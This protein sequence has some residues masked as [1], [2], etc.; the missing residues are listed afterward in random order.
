MPIGYHRDVSAAS[1]TEA[2][3]RSDSGA[4]AAQTFDGKPVAP[5]HKRGYWPPD[6]IVL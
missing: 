5:P 4:V 3:V 2:L 6:N 1:R